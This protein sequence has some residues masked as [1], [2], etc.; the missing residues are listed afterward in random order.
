MKNSRKIGSITI[1]VLAFLFVLLPCE[2]VLRVYEQQIRHF[3][4]GSIWSLS[5]VIFGLGVVGI[6]SLLLTGYILKRIFFSYLYVTDKDLE[7]V[8]LKNIKLKKGAIVQLKCTVDNR[9]LRIH[10]LIGEITDI[11]DDG[12]FWITVNLSGIPTSFH[13]KR[14]DFRVIKKKASG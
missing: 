11:E 6:C 13:L 4:S 9:V 1:L 3:V 7:E 8:Y 5:L 10:G 2:I 14:E 12:T